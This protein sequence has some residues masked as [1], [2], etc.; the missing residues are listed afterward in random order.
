MSYKRAKAMEDTANAQ[1][2][3]NVHT[4]TG[5]R[6]ERLRDAIGHLGHASDSVRLGAAYQLFHLAEDTKALSGTVLKILCA[7]IRRTTRQKTYQEEQ[8]ATPSEEVQTL[9]TLLFVDNPQTFGSNRA[10]LQGCWLNGANLEHARLQSANLS[11]ASLHKALLTSVNLQGSVLIDAQLQ[12]SVVAYAR[13]DGSDMSGVQ[14]Q[15]SVLVGSSMRGSNLHRGQLQLAHLGGVKLQGALLSST[16]MQA[17][18][19]SDTCMHGVTPKYSLGPPAER[20]R[21][22]V[23]VDSDLSEVIFSG[24]LTEETLQ[25]IVEGLPDSY[26]SSTLGCLSDHVGK[27]ESSHPP[28]GVITGSYDR[29]QAESWLGSSEG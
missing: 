6:Q 8:P 11:Y 10:E 3:A 25:T 20:I 26:V 9:L 12:G 17:A 28:P 7:H 22:F 18:S 14:L 19:S 16:Q 23:D 2:A 5:Q 4:E 24:G 27:P 29:E 1:V 21:E 15:H 13:L